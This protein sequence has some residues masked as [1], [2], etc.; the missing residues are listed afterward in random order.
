MATEALS[1][2]VLITMTQNQIYALPGS[3][4][5]LFSNTAGAAFEMSN[6]PTFASSIAQT[7][8][9]GTIG[10]LVGG[11]I[12]STAGNALVMLKKF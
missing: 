4:C 10:A 6:D 2:G 3:S 12:R 7:A 1:T 5:L 11:F 8:L 9:E